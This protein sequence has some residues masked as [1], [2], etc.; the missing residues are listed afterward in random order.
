MEIKYDKSSDAVYIKFAVEGGHQLKQ[1]H[2]DG[3]WPINV[4]VSTSGTVMGIEILNASHVL[5]AEVLE[6]GKI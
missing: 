6:K 1:D 4:D 5:N 3:E 2:V